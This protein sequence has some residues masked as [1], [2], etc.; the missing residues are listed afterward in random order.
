MLMPFSIFND[1]IEK[2]RDGMEN[3]GNYTRRVIETYILKDDIYVTLRD[4]GEEVE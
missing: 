4:L 1:S 3:R 2:M